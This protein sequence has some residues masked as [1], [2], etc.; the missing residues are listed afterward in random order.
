MQRLTVPVIVVGNI[1]VGGSGKTPLTIALARVLQQRGWRPGVVSRGY[2]GRSRDRPRR[3]SV[4]DD[5]L[6]VGDEPLLIVRHCPVV[7]DPRR[8]RGASRLVEL[9]CD[10]VLADDGLQHYALG[11]DIELVMVDGERRFGNGFC[12]PAGPLREPLSRLREVDFIVANGAAQSGEFAMRLPMRTVVSLRQPEQTHPLADWRDRAVHAVAGI[13]HPE[14]FFRQL[15]EA[16]LRVEAHPF[17]DHHR[18]RPEELAFPG[19]KPIL[20]T[21]KDAVKCRLFATARHWV[22]PVEAE[23]PA[24]LLESLCARLVHVMQQRGPD[25]QETA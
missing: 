5:P 24:A 9:G 25:G 22:V 20:M 8:P 1:T 2:G 10:V 11:R 6:D 15:R 21:E 16:G 18:F 19:D 12:L 7:V 14:R 23:L 13:G 4:D 17:P 3:V